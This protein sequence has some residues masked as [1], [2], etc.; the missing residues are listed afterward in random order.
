MNSTSTIHPRQIDCPG[1]FLLVRVHAA[2]R[3][4]FVWRIF[5]PQ[6][7]T[8]SAQS[9]RTT[10]KMYPSYGKH[11]TQTPNLQSRLFPVCNPICLI[12]KVLPILGFCFTTDVRILAS[13]SYALNWFYNT[14]NPCHIKIKWISSWLLK[15]Q[16]QP[17]I[18][19][20]LIPTSL[21]IQTWGFSWR[22]LNPVQI[23]HLKVVRR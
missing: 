1:S 3:I 22:M 6:G 5:N 16:C 4:A 21:G 13:H 15:T 10:F 2:N 7:R 8:A 17:T 11:F 12:F 23:H 20:T 14:R 18:H 19:P 9:M